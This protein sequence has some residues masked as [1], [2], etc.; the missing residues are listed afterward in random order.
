MKKLFAALAALLAMLFTLPACA[1]VPVPEMSGR[2]RVKP[3]ENGR[4][5]YLYFDFEITFSGSFDDIYSIEYTYTVV[6]TATGEQVASYSRTRYEDDFTEE[7]GVYVYED[8]N[9]VLTDYDNVI[10]ASDYNAY[11]TVNYVDKAQTSVWLPAV[12]G[13]L[14]CAC[15]VAIAVFAVPAAIKRK[16]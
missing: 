3:D 13:T 2:L 10:S 14:G 15:L 16:K 6:E 11:W 7:D 1:S 8:S 9:A 12:F 5:R 4:R